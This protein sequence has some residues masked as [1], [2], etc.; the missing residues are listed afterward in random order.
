MARLQ[1]LIPAYNAAEYLAETL[2]SVLTQG[3][4]SLEVVVVDNA[5][6]DGT[7]DVVRSFAD[8]GVRYVRNDVNVGSSRNHNLALDMATGDYVKLLSADDVLLPGTLAKQ[9]AAL[10]THPSAGVATCNCRVTDQHL[11]PL[12]ETTYLPGFQKGA[13]AIASC[14]WKAANLVGAPSNT[15]LRRSAIQDA[16]LDPALK[17]VGDLD[18]FCQILT[19]S[20]FVNIDVVGFLYRRHDATDSTL[21]CPP[22]IRWHDE[23]LFS[24]R[25][26]GGPLSR[27]RIAYRVARDWVKFHPALRRGQR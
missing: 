9:I 19:R 4:T 20:D 25:Y 27:L 13:Q 12:R 7:A 17:W 1:V 6:T 11:N 15:M 8:R 16:R 10:D 14:A 18:F 2:E 26:G 3:V 24:R 22:T 23:L 21:S 5:S